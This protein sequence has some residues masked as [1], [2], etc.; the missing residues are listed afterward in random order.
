MGTVLC[1]ERAGVAW[2]EGESWQRERERE[3]QAVQGCWQQWAGKQQRLHFIPSL[4][5]ARSMAGLRPPAPLSASWAGSL[6]LTVLPQRVS[7]T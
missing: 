7:R 4:S 3:T 6:S 1:Q 2:Q 5:A